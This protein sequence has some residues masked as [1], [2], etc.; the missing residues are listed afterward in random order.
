MIRCFRKHFQKRIKQSLSTY[1][2]NLSKAIRSGESKI[3]W[4]FGAQMK[5]LLLDSATSG[6]MVE[7]S[8]SN[9]SVCIISVYLRAFTLLRTHC[10]Y[11]PERL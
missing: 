6:P 7:F 3:K 5:E 8:S 4:T 2:D 10:L 1:K 9:N 11:N